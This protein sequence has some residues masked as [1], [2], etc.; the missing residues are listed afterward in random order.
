MC[1]DYFDSVLIV[2]LLI[3]DYYLC[4]KLLKFAT[5]C[6]IFSPLD[7]SIPGRLSKGRL[8]ECRVATEFEIKLPDKE[9]YL[10]CNRIGRSV[11]PYVCLRVFVAG[12][13]FLSHNCLSACLVVLLSTYKLWVL[14]NM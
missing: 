10:K 8:S 9:K 5:L 11:L 13:T 3:K 14:C 2:F 1:W 12:K 6:L 4:N 7:G